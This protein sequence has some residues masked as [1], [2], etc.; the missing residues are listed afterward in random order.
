MSQYVL[1][2]IHGRGV[3]ESH[4]EPHTNLFCKAK[5]KRKVVAVF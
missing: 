2:S 5:G 3:L 1:R 4:S